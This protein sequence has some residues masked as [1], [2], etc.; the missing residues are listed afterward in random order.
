MSTEDQL[1]NQAFKKMIKYISW[2]GLVVCLAIVIMRLIFLGEPVSSVIHGLAFIALGLSSLVGIYKFNNYHIGRWAIL[3][4]FVF[5][6]PWQIYRTGGLFSFGS[7]WLITMIPYAVIFFSRKVYWTVIAWFGIFVTYLGLN[8]VPFEQ[9]HFEPD[10]LIARSLTSVFA[11]FIIYYVVKISMIEKE[12][13]KEAVHKMESKEF[14][15]KNAINMA[16]EINN[17]LAIIALKSELLKRKGTDS[18]ELGPILESV[19]RISKS[20]EDYKALARQE[21]V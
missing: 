15:F 17:P 20:I 19:E 9:Y 1:E 7:V 5:I 21:E 11:F 13:L 12:R 14:L 4:Y 8:P 18:E 6:Q 2:T 16:H 3:L 10:Q